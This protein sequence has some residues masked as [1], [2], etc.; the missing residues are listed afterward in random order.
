MV[1]TKEDLSLS[2]YRIYGMLGYQFTKLLNF[3][4]GYLNI[5]YNDQSNQHML[6]FFLTHKLFLY[7]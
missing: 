7:D 1:N 5:K 3:Q 2:Q 6:Q 4:F